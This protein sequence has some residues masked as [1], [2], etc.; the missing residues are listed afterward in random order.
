MKYGETLAQRSVLEWL[1][2]NLDY[3]EIKQLIKRDTTG[4][5][6]VKTPGARVE[7][8]SELFDVFMDQLSR[9]DL[10]VKSKAGEVDRRLGH[11]TRQVAAL[12]RRD[13]GGQLSA[14]R[15]DRYAKIEQEIERASYDIQ[16]LSR[17]V[18]VQHTGFLKLLKKY[19]KW[20]G[21]S[22]LSDRF[23]PV[24]ESP[25][26]FHKLGFQKNVLQ[27]ADLLDAVR[28][29]FAGPPVRTVTS[30]QP[31]THV[32][33][34]GKSSQKSPLS[35][36]F[37]Q[38]IR[39]PR[40]T[41]RHVDLDISLAISPPLAS[42]GGKA[43]FWVHYDHLIELQVLLLKN[44][45]LQSVS[46]T[47]SAYSSPTLTRRN[48]AISTIWKDDEVVLV[49]LDDLD[50]FSDVQSSA[51]VDQVAKA[52]SRSAGQV[53]WCCRDHEAIIAVSDASGSIHNEAI[54][55]KEENMSAK[56]KRKHIEKLFNP[57]TTEEH[58][59]I[60][61]LM[62]EKKEKDIAKIRSWLQKHKNI[63]PLVKII[64]KRTR[65]AGNVPEGRAWAFLDKDIRMLKFGEGCS[66]IGDS[67]DDEFMLNSQNRNMAE[68]P[69]AV[70][71]VH[72]E[73]HKVPEFLK[74]LETSHMVEQVRGFSLD[75]HAV[76]V[77]HQP[78]KMSPPFWLHALNK[79]IRKT[80][81]STPRHSRRSSSHLIFSSASSNLS[82]GATSV[83]ATHDSTDA[84]ESSA[85]LIG[86]TDYSSSSGLKK[87]SLRKLKRSHSGA[88]AVT[89]ERYWSEYN[90]DED[91]EE[92]YT[93]L[94][95][96][97]K[98]PDND[99]QDQSLSEFIKNGVSSSLRSM[100]DL[101]RSSTET[102]ERTPLLR[103]S[104]A[105]SDLSSDIDL[106][107][108]ARA[109]GTISGINYSTFTNPV[110]PQVV[111]SSV[112]L[113]FVF[114]SI[115]SLVTTAVLA[116]NSSLMNHKHKLGSGIL[117]ID[118]EVFSGVLVSLILSGFG[119]AM[120]V[121]ANPRV[122]F[123]H[124]A[125]VWVTFVS[126]CIGSGALLAMVGSSEVGS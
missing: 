54:G 26:A 98:A 19:K 116:T 32:M 42:G 107:A 64:A 46:P 48:S 118:L 31:R 50:R 52:S 13:T 12:E 47:P 59:K 61:E 72:W 110:T 83:I 87:K 103:T 62:E 93:I 125:V 82:T 65:F 56:L 89:G 126:V 71:E 106:E 69:H 7:F 115:A 123:V 44:L 76:A 15:V 97:S 57:P 1:P 6:L 91:N 95:H 60:Y 100:R 18:H 70:L 29:A 2:Y 119:L 55:Q 73:G 90:D 84:M 45:S 21:S 34:E 37:S 25:T 39:D 78:R 49:V 111:S 51:T 40:H 35:L 43:V 33:F 63:M 22:G 38:A 67:D 27:V 102:R 108:R 124:K 77:L 121:M 66:W 16:C 104:T 80:P 24:L 99:V 11:C 79:D 94:I 101:F 109:N 75:V 68:F 53:R 122:G 105:S 96:P 81:L 30:T 74:E 5:P 9:I 112:H 14:K 92:P 17:F 114:A 86:E 4:R 41:E 10:F 85:T 36:D 8:E 120:F 117:A 28:A 88:E 23:L 20:T 3:T 58:G 113:V